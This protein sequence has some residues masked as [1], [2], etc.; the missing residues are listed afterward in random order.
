MDSQG[1][2]QVDDEEASCRLLIRQWL[3]PSLRTVGS[4]CLQQVEELCP[5]EV[6]PDRLPIPE[7]ELDDALLL[8]EAR[9]R[10]LILGERLP[11]LGPSGPTTDSHLDLATQLVDEAAQ[12]ARGLRIHAASMCSPKR[13]V[14]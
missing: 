12:Q 10:L 4:C 9:H 5:V 11:V 2:V 13:H 3:A 1:L 14:M 8:V 6:R 7:L